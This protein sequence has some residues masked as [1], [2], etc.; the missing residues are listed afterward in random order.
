VDLENS[1][2]P[3]RALT[4]RLIL[5]I[6]GGDLASGERLPSTTQSQGASICASPCAPPT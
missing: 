5:G 2:V 1:E 6:V 4:T 3:I